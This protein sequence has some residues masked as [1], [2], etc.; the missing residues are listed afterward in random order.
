M[1]PFS[2][3]KS[4]IKEAENPGTTITN[5]EGNITYM[6]P[7][8][9]AMF[10]ISNV[11]DILGIKWHAL[12]PERSRS[13][14]AGQLF[15]NEHFK[16]NW[17][18]IVDAQTKSG[19]IFQLAIS[20]SPISDGGMIWTGMNHSKIVAQKRE[21]DKQAQVSREFLHSLAHELRTP[22]AALRGAH[23]LISK[24]VETSNDSRLVRY[25]DLQ[26]QGILALSQI[27]DQVVLLSD[28]EL[29]NGEYDFAECNPLELIESIISEGIQ[30]TPPK[31]PIAIINTLPP[32]FTLFV[33]EATFKAAIENIISNAKKYTPEDKE[34]VV[35][36]FLSDGMLSI[37][38]KDQGRGIPTADQAKIF[39]P[40]FRASNVGSVPGS[41]L[42]LI[43]AKRAIE[44]HGGELSFS[45]DVETGSVFRVTIPVKRKIANL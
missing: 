9:L 11:N 5:F 20:I 2:L 39:T 38:T 35:R 14:I 8:H 16:G 24:K 42:G 43:I 28:L 4:A 41:G 34:I 10:G 32:K 33:D 3:V 13:I 15:Q 31:K 27:I 17:A 37:E 30:T 18:D 21:V 25:L 1:N 6:N 19:E 23:F 7:E 26:H 44:R 45:S 36:I 29:G 12:F 22:L 40:Y